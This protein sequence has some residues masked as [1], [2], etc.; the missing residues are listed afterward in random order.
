MIDKLYK[1]KKGQTD[2]KLSFKAQIV[3]TIDNIDKQVSDLEKSLATT[4]VNR[5]GAIS[6]F[7]VLEMHKQ[8]LKKDIVKLGSQRK[9]LVDKLKKVDLE[10]IELQKE[11]EQFSY[12]LNEQRKKEFNKQLA[13]EEEAASEFVQSKYISS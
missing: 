9:I 10:L 7:A 5:Y 8:S 4:S 12:I 11:A 6:D 13:L 2:Q 1:L 3:E